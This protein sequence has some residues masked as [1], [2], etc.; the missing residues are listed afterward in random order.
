MVD[1]KTREKIKEISQEIES[2]SNISTA[3][4]EFREIEYPTKQNPFTL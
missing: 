1:K 2:V 3:E 4:G